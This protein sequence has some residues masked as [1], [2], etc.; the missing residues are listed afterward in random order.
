MSA[1][2]TVVLPPAP[3]RRADALRY[4]MQ[5]VRAE[6]GPIPQF[7]ECIAMAEGKIGC[8]AVWREFGIRNSEFGIAGAGTEGA[9]G[10][11][12]TLD[13]G[14]AVTGSESLRRHLAGCDGV[15][16]FAATAGMEMDRLILRAKALSP[17][18]GLL[19]HGIGAAVIEEACDRLCGQ[20]AKAFPDRALRPRFSPGYG[21]LPLAMQRDIFATL[22]C[23]RRLGLT[24]T[25]TLLMQPSKSVTAL[26]GLERLKGST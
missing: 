26:V 7:E 3:I 5:P 10:E 23:E 13:L 15:I 21:D 12:G 17:L 19:M 8:R 11:K 20:L 22:D 25:D 18:H 6:T 24:L 14:F 4:A 9:S 1:P 2:V 16:L